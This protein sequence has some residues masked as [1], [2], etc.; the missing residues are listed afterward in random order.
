MCISEWRSFLY[1]VIERNKPK[2]VEWNELERKRN[3][4]LC[5]LSNNFYTQYINT[6]DN[7]FGNARGNMH[8]KI[9]ITYSIIST[10]YVVVGRYYLNFIIMEY[11]STLFKFYYLWILFR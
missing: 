5:L 11:H 1:T 8:D 2:K 9:L 7:L 6:N 3:E 4:S 10:Q